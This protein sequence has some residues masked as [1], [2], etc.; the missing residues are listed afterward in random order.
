MGSC[1]D[2]D[3]DRGGLKKLTAN[4]VGLPE[5]NRAFEFLPPPPSPGD[6]GKRYPYKKICHGAQC[7]IQFFFFYGVFRY[8]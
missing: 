3:I 5:Y 6:K 7:K 8:Q 4:E 1:P 2:T